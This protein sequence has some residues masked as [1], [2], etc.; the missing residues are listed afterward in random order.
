MKRYTNYL[1]KLKDK[2]TLNLSSELSTDKF[3]NKLFTDKYFKVYNKDSDSWLIL[4]TDIVAMVQLNTNE[5]IKDLKYV[6]FKNFLG[7]I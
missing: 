5:I 6:K 7:R 1:V 3:V 4:T 2:T